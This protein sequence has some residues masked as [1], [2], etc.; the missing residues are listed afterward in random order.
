MASGKLYCQ[1]YLG[2]GIGLVASAHAIAAVG[3]DGM[4]EVDINPNP[5]RTELVGDMLEKT[6]SFATLGTGAGLGYEPDISKIAD[7]RV[8]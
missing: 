1:H 4:L 7:F 8:L 2:R 3:G 6:P 5:L